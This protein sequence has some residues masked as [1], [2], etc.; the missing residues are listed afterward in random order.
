MAIATLRHKDLG[1]DRRKIDSASALR[2]QE[3]QITRKLKSL[4]G[5]L[6]GDN[7]PRPYR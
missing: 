1:L 6:R 7:R 2:M 4:Q 5:V 3:A